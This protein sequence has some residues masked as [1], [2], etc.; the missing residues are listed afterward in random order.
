MPPLHFS[1]ENGHLGVFDYLIIDGED[2]IS[3]DN[4]IDIWNFCGLH[5]IILLIMII[6]VLLNISLIMELI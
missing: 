2:I 1:S 3:Q 4:D 6:W 5:F